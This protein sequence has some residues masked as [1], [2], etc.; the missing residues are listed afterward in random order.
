MTPS[1]LVIPAAVLAELIAHCRAGLPCEA[2]GLLA[3]VAG[4]VSHHFP[5][6]NALA[7]PTRFL[8]DATDTIAAAK[9]CRLAGVEVLAV[10]HSHPTS[11]PVP[12][13]RDLAERYGVMTLIVGLAG[14]VADVRAWHLSETGY[15]AAEWEVG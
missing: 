15:T 6:R 1:R 2:G 10:Y 4:Q 14:A 12:S 9:A 5:L 11:A 3:G 7:S 8:S 13:V